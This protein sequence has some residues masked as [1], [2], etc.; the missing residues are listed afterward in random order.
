[1][2]PERFTTLLEAARQGSEAAWQD[3][4]DGLA[5]IVLGYLRANNAPDPEDVLSEVFLQ[6]ARDISRFEGEEPG[7][8]SWVFTIAHHRLIDA[9]RHSARRPV[10]LSPEPPE[11]SGRADDAA[12]EALARIGTESVHRVLSAL[13]DDQRAVLLLRVLAD[14]SIEDVAKAVGKRPGAVKAL[15]RRGLA[16]AKREL[17]Q[18][19]AEAR[20][21]GGGEYGE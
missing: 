12:E 11:P 18:G 4:Y 16:A 13:S 1:M 21:R 7:F 2:S 14:M 15:Q 17:A 20:S 8:R 9:R 19:R 3:L 10:D 5:P 6:V